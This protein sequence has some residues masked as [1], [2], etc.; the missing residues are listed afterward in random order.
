MNRHERRAK[1]SQDRASKL[2]TK[3][4]DD[5]SE[6]DATVGRG[7]DYFDVVVV[8]GAKEYGDIEWTMTSRV[9]GL[10]PGPVAH[11]MASALYQLAATIEKGI[12][13]KGI[14]VDDRAKGPVGES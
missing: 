14:L 1:V 7:R 9:K 6:I 3:E 10:M 8:V 2:V 4:K 13:T 12:E 11:A 5:D